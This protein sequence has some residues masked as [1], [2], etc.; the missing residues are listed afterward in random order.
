MCGCG[1][2]LHVLLSFEFMHFILYVHKHAHIC[3]D[4]QQPHV[5]DMPVTVLCDVRKLFKISLL[6]FTVW[7]LVPYFIHF[8]NC[9]SRLY[10]KVC[11]V[12]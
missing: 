10:G 6:M 7:M 9:A 3:E 2:M 12:L 1:I 4:A 5:R 11:K 8:E